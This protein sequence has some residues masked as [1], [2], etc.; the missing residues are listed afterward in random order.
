MNHYWSVKH[1]LQI[2]CKTPIKQKPDKCQKVGA[3]DM[4]IEK[5]K[6]EQ[7]PK[8]FS[9][10]KK[11]ISILLLNV[12]NTRGVGRIEPPPPQNYPEFLGDQPKWV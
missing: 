11:K 4:K 6:L 3:C 1:A 10:L 8:I 2:V 5:I 7:N 9:H 12:G